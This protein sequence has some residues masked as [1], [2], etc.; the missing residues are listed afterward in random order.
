MHRPGTIYREAI[1]YQ[2]RRRFTDY[3]K[4]E[5]V[6]AAKL[7]G[8]KVYW[9][10]VSDGFGFGYL[11]S[12]KDTDN[13]SRFGKNGEYQFETERERKKIKAVPNIT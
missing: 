11:N 3:Y 10:N 8:S 9:K 4:M 1:F 2:E 5:P 13:A 12:R 6:R 7:W